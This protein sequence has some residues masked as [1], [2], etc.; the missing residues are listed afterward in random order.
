MI[1]F[2]NKYL[3]GTAV[4]V[5]LILAGIFYTVRLRAFHLLKP[6][7]VI[8][9]LTKKNEGDGISPFRAVTLAL[10]GTLGVGNIVGVAAA[11]G[12]G[13]FGAVFWMWIS[14]LCAMLLKYAEIVL[15]MRHRRYDSVGAPHGAAMYYIKDMFCSRALPRLGRMIA[16]VFAI[17]CILNA[18]SMGSMIQANAI[19]ESL[20]GV[21]GIPPLA[22]GIALALLCVIIISRGTE[23]MA[24]FTEML[25][26]L[27]TLGYI[28]ISL[29]V[30]ILRRDMLWG[31]LCRIIR[32]AFSPVATAGGISG[33][34]LSRSLRYGTMRGLI[35]NEAG[36]GTAPAAHASSNAKSPA[37]Q[38][39]WGIFEVFTDTIVLCTMT[40]LVIIVSFEG[41]LYDGSWIMMTI[42]AYAAVLGRSASV[43]LSVAVLCFGFATI[44]CWAH[45]GVESVRYLNPKPGYKNLFIFIYC[46]SSLVGAFPMSEAI[47][48]AADFAIGAMTLINVTVICFMSSEVKFET[49]IYFKNND[50]KAKNK[51]LRIEKR[52]TR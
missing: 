41:A 13:G 2:I 12:L 8:R 49:E 3:L 29:A 34:L 23:G 42:N 44:V 30:L 46:A 33:F 36:C 9:S 32:D 26:P 28:V 37:E 7:A 45:Y 17:L 52:S 4:P 27:M 35:S 22:C 43:F 18:I 1:E 14:A 10:A 5:L 40:A 48:S 39:F 38:G 16:S 15:A 11:I 31:A 19:S 47:W 50:K 20:G 6:A 51:A 21:F 25:V 24:K